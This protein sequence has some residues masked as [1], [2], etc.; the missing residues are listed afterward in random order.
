MPEIVRRLLPESDAAAYCGVT[1]RWLRDRR[2]RG[3]PEGCQPGPP[4][5]V[6]GRLV[7]YDIQDLDTWIE[8]CPRRCS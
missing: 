5:T 2:W 6:L 8:K 3:T 1:V 7:R 4:V